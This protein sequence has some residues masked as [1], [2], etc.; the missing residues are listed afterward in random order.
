MTQELLN[1]KGHQV[2]ADFAFN[3]KQ[4]NTKADGIQLEREQFRDMAFGIN[5]SKADRWGET[6]FR[7]EFGLGVDWFGATE[8]SSAKLAVPNGNGVFSR[9]NITLA[10]TQKLPGDAYTIV[11]GTVQLTQENLND[12]DQW[13]SGGTYFG[14]GYSEGFLGGDS[15]A[16]VSW[17][18]HIPCYFLPK[19]WQL[20]GDDEPLRK[21]VEFVQFVDY[22]WNHFNKVP[23]GTDSSQTILGI[24]VG[25]RA[26]LTHFVSGRID[27]GFPMLRQLGNM[28]APRIHFGLTGTF[29]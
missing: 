28:S 17:E 7:N 5:Y 11:Q 15:G 9:D 27:L 21:K 3:F 1:K 26:Q 19:T 6:S 18:T 14:R 12:F 4:N 29:F 23:R 16:Y 24:G 22:A 8:R 2:S 10:R 20:P 25:L 13:G